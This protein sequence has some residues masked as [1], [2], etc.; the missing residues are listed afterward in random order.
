[1]TWVNARLTEKGKCQAL[2]IKATLESDVREMKI[3]RPGKCYTSPLARSL[4]TTRIAF[5]CLEWPRDQP[6]KPMIKEA[7]RERLGR[8]TCDRHSTRSWIESNY[9]EF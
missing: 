1:M 8:H 4:E 6:F 5:S 7:L 2:E 9:A 3:P